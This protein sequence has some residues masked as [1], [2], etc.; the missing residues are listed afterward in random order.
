MDPVL[1]DVGG[2]SF[3]ASVIEREIAVRS[4]AFVSDGGD[5]DESVQTSRK[6]LS[7]RP[8]HGN[9]NSIQVINTLE[10]CRVPEGIETAFEIEHEKVRS[11]RLKSIH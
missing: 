5:W 2:D 9:L 7:S 11:H 4:V 1:L 10:R 3:T 8:Y 6:Y